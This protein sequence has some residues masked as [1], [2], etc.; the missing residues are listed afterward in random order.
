[1]GRVRIYYKMQFAK[2]Q[3]DLMFC[4]PDYS[5]IRWGRVYFQRDTTPPKVEHVKLFQAV[6]LH[7]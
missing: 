5:W 6:K 3:L 1:M 2:R 4:D 7:Y